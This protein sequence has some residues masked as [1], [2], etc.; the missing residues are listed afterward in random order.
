M[1]ARKLVLKQ[2]AIVL[3]GEVI[4]SALMV[5]IF[6][7]IGKFDSSVLWGA[8][9]GAVL[10]SANFFI[11]AVCASVAADRAAAQNVRGGKSLIQISYFGRIL[12]LFLIL[13]VCAKSGRFNIFALVLP[14]LFERPALMFAEFFRKSGETKS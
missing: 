5:G 4:G 14:L 12:G 3:A 7:L 2:S 11:M 10:A 13:F 8:V 6:A 1:E 9:I